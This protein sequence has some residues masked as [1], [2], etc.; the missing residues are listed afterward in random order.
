[1][2]SP[3]EGLGVATSPDARLINGQH[4]IHAVPALY[5]AFAD[6]SAT[7]ARLAARPRGTGLARRGRIYL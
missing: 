6:L 1:M 7:P 4:W 3:G 2:D 5:A